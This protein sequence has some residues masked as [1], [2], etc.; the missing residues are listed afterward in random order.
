MIPPITNRDNYMKQCETEIRLI[1]ETF[2]EPA[3][4]ELIQWQ[5][6]SGY[7]Y[8]RYYPVGTKFSFNNGEMIA[9]KPDGSVQEHIS[10][11]SDD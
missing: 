7:R 11:W 3:Q 8:C 4:I 6:R 1:K 5:R 10:A 2:H 9:F